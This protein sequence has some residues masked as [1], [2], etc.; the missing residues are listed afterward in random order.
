MHTHT[1]IDAKHTPA[2]MKPAM[3]KELEK[4]LLSQLYGP[5]TS[6]LLMHTL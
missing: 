5:V 2:M 6:S 3:L 4:D 1:L